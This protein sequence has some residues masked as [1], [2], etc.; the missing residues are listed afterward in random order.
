MPI[1]IIDKGTGN[2]FLIP[3]KTMAEQSATIVF[4]GNGNRVSIGEN[5]VLNGA[6]IRLIT[7]SN[8]SCEANVR[9][10][11]IE[12]IAALRGVVEIGAYSHLTWKAQLYLHEPGR[13][14]IGERCLIASGTSFTISDM[15]SIID[16]KSGQRINPAKDIVLGEKVWLAEDVRVLKGAKIG[17]GSIIG[18]RSIVTNSIPENSLA[19]G[20]PAKVIR[21]DVTWKT[22]LI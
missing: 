15:H 4:E 20:V 19:V 2:Q 8:F 6:H 7:D 16:I 14:A 9:L 3:E 5:C 1:R 18:I 13:I 21:T 12:V 10:A 11:A 17:S 22:E